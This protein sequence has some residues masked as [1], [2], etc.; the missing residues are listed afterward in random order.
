ML[1]TSFHRACASVYLNIHTDVFSVLF[2]PEL[3]VISTIIKHL[4]GMVTGND[5]HYYEYEQE[6]MFLQPG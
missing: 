5:Y 1:I 6:S 3:L 4:A 2:A